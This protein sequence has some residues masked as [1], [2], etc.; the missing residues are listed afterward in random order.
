MPRK[1]PWRLR[2]GE[3]ELVDRVRIA[4]EQIDAEEGGRLGWVVKFARDDPK[5][6]LPSDRESNGYRLLA[7]GYPWLIPAV[8]GGIGLT[9]GLKPRDV[10]DL[11]AEIQKKLRE[12]VTVPSGQ[13]VAIPTDGLKTVLVRSAAP[14][15]KPAQF[16][17]SR[18]GPFVTMLWQ[19]IAQLIHNSDR[20]IACPTC[21]E[22]FLA[23]RKK[24]FCSP[25][26]TQKW[27]DREKVKAKQAG[28]GG[29]K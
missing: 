15:K 20:L 11:H 21:G 27:H 4:G 29:K 25:K 28:V 7:L 2:P 24:L 9:S 8:R 19:E 6:W 16:G 22:P 12:L 17:F 10:M 1:K 14:G 18:G 3:E 23:L 26:C 5:R 13:K